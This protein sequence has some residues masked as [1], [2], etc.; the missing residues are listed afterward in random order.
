MKSLSHCDDDVIVLERKF[1]SRLSALAE[2]CPISQTQRI[3]A[4]L[5]LIVCVFSNL[6][7]M[8]FQVYGLF[9]AFFVQRLAAATVLTV[10]ICIAKSA[11]K[12]YLLFRLCT[13][14]NMTRQHAWQKSRLLN[15]SIRTDLW[16]FL[17]V[18]SFSSRLERFFFEW[19]WS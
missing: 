14:N 10:L 6:H 3:E 12:I 8:S 11:S 19:I 5:K 4:E 2:S 15:Y 16:H 13:T 9:A 18:I 17:T 7:F 1:R